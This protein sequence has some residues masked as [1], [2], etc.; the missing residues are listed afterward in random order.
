MRSVPSVLTFSTFPDHGIFSILS[1]MSLAAPSTASRHALP[2]S[3]SFQLLA[4]LKSI[5]SYR[6]LRPVVDSEP[7]SFSAA[8]TSPV[9]VFT[10]RISTAA[11]AVFLVIPPPKSETPPETV[12]C[13][14]PNSL[15]L[16]ITSN[17]TPRALPTFGA[18]SGVTTP[19]CPSFCSSNTLSNSARSITTNFPDFT[20]AVVNISE[21]PTPT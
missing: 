5:S 7:S 10:R 4:S 16:P 2:I 19:D 8:T 12:F 20:S 13:F 1:A 21:T 11:R 6:T 3:V 9:V 18:D 17:S 15:T 14:V